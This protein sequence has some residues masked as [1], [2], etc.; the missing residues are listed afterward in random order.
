MPGLMELELCVYTV[1]SCMPLSTKRRFTY[2]EHLTIHTKGSRPAI[3]KRERS[4]LHSM[5]SQCLPSS[6]V[7]GPRRPSFSRRGSNPDGAPLSAFVDTAC[8]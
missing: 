4:P 6:T 8:T 3:G 1:D 7:E 5:T 2:K